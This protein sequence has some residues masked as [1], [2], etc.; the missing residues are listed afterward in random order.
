M[1]ET[2][3]YQYMESQDSDNDNAFKAHLLQ[4]EID[5]FKW[6][7]GGKRGRRI[8]WRLLEKAGV[9]H[10]S[11]TGNALGTAFNEGKRNYG[12]Y[13]MDMIHTHCPEHYT[14]MISERQAQ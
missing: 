8:V 1:T 9:F 3:P 11:F 6:L 12:L 7:M 10:N 14:T 13:L 5:D 2:N 4:L